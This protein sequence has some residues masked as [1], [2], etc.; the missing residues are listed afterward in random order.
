MGADIG[1]SKAVVSAH[2][3]DRH[4]TKIDETRKVGIWRILIRTLC[5]INSAKAT[6]RFIVL[7]NLTSKAI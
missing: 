2:A 7:G 1:L 6:Q 3:K 4:R 5:N